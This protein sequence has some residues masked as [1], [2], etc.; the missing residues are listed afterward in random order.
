[1]A[2]GDRV[3]TKVHRISAGLFPLALI[4]AGYASLFLSRA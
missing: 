3:V 1:M 4:P 2:T